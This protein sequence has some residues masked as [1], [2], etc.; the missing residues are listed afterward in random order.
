MPCVLGSQKRASDSPGPG[1][2]DS[3]QPGLLQEQQGILT[4]EHL[5]SPLE[6]NSNFP[7]NITHGEHCFIF[8][9]ADSL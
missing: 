3:Y 4:S 2:T 6:I 1:I 5:P 8:D 9:K 7:R